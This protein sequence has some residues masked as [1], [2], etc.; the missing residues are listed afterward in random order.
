MILRRLLVFPIGSIFISLFLVMLVYMEVNETLFEPSFHKDQLARNDIYKFVE[1]ELFTYGAKEIAKHRFSWDGNPPYLSL[2]TL[3]LSESDIVHSS[4]AAVP[5][6]WLAEHVELIIDHFIPYLTGQTDTFSV[7]IEIEDRLDIMIEQMVDLADKSDLSMVSEDIESNV[8]DILSYEIR[9]DKQFSMTDDLKVIHSNLEYYVSESITEEWVREQ[10]IGVLHEIRSYMLFP[11][12]DLKLAV[13]LKSPISVG[14]SLARDEIIEATS[15]A[16]MKSILSRYEKFIGD[17]IVLEANLYLLGTIGIPVQA[18]VSDQEVYALL[19]DVFPKEWIDIHSE[20]LVDRAWLYLSGDSDELNLVIPVNERVDILRDSIMQILVSKFYKSADTIYSCESSRGALVY[21]YTDGTSVCVLSWMETSYVKALYSEVLKNYLGDSIDQLAGD[22]IDSS[23]VNMSD[24]K[25]E[26]SEIQKLSTGILGKKNS[27]NLVQ[28]RQ[29]ISNGWLLFDD[30][31]LEVVKNNNLG[32]DWV[33]V[34]DNIKFALANGWVIDQTSIQNLLTETLGDDAVESFNRIRYQ[35]KTS[36]SYN[37]FLGTLC[38]LLL[39]LIGFLGGNRW[40]T[41]IYW[42]L[43]CLLLAALVS[44]VICNTFSN[45]AAATALEILA[46]W[47]TD[48]Q[49]V[50]LFATQLRDL[51]YGYAD[52]FAFGIAKKSGVL[53]SASILGMLLCF[54]L[55]ALIGKKMSLTGSRVSGIGPDAEFQDN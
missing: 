15:D 13:N 21:D 44:I 23:N 25:L 14:F 11:Q 37:Y 20:I 24:V 36:S 2:P 8:L 16:L 29:D 48:S 33:P 27:L 46:S 17:G 3:G 54:S 51:L 45:I 12:S 49:I 35:L 38:L 31:D 34:F 9:P 1:N 30:R 43:G 52:D 39:A 32:K 40:S 18:F 47:K 42:S 41:R 4:R 19:L 5:S 53:L 28:M 50:S 6:E 55:S 26:I 10:F 22:L 7:N